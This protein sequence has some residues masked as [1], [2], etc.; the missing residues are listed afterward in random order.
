[1]IVNNSNYFNHE[2]LTSQKIMQAPK[3][4]FL[5]LESSITQNDREAFEESIKIGQWKG[6]L[7]KTA[8][9]IL[10]EFSR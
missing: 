10:A 3:L 2:N 8:F 1:M 6:P 5:H 7:E 9:F 4:A